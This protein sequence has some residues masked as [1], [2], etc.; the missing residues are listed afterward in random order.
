MTDPVQ[1]QLI[2]ARR[3]QILDAATAVFARKGFH[4][5]TIKDVAGEAGIADGTIYNYFKNK[6]ALLLGIFDRMRDLVQPE[7]DEVAALTEGDLRT[8]LQAFLR[9]PLTTLSQDDFKLF[10]VVVA[11][12]LVDEELRRLYQEQ[13]LEPTLSFAEIYLQKW[14]EQRAIAHLDIAL[15]IRSISAVVMGCM[16]QYAIGDSVLRANWEQLPDFL[17]GLLIDGLEQSQR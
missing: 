1:Q 15:T 8:F 4:P 2:N 11:E 10:K 17:T 7:A 14:A 12:M 6:T 13:I 5:A 3:N 16:I 9:L